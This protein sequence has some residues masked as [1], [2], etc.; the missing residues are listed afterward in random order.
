MIK[1][2]ASLAFIILTL[3]IWPARLPASDHDAS[4]RTIRL[5]P[6]R[7]VIDLLQP[8][9]E[10]RPKVG[11]VLSGGGARGF[12]HI[13]VLMGLEEAGIPIDYIVGS[14]MGSIIGGLYAAGFSPDSLQQV[15]ID[16]EW[17]RLFLDDP[18]RTNLFVAQKADQTDHT[19]QFRLNGIRPSIPG[20]LSAGQKLQHLLT[21]LTAPAN[22]LAAGDFS[23]L[24]IPFVAIATDLISG[25][26]VVLEHGNL[27]EAMR[28]S[29]AVPIVFRPVERQ[30]RLLVD[31]ALVEPMPVDLIRQR[32][33]DIVIAVNTQD[34]LRPKDQLT[35]P[36]DI[37]DQ[38]I[39]ISVIQAA[40]NQETR[41]DVMITPAIGNHPSSRFSNIDTLIA[42]GLQGVRPHIASIREL[43]SQYEEPLDAVE[44][45]VGRVTITGCSTQ[46]SQRLAKVLNVQPGRHL[47]VDM[48]RA[49]LSM[50]YALGPYADAEAEI[51]GEYLDRHV[52]YRVTHAPVLSDLVIEGATL[53]QQD[54]LRTHIK[55]KT[56]QPINLQQLH[57][58]GKKIL[59]RYHESGYVMADLEQ[60]TVNLRTGS[61]FMKI[62]EGHVVDIHV[63]GHRRTREWA[64][65]REMRLRTGDVY[66]A[67]RV[68]R[69]IMNIYS[70]G[71]FESVTLDVEQ[72]NRRPRLVIAVKERPS[73]I[74]KLGARY[75]RERNG[76]GVLSLTEANLF[77]TGS[78]LTGRAVF[79]DRRQRYMLGFR[80][81]RVFK[82]Y[83]T[84]RML[85][86]YHQDDRYV[87]DGL[88]QIGDFREKRSGLQ[89]TIGR[90][91]S[92]L[93]AVS[94][95][96]RVEGVEVQTRAG[97]SPSGRADIRSLTLRSQVDNLDRYPFPSSGHHHDVWL[98][99]AGEALGGHQRFLRGYT[100]LA[101]YRTIARYL[102]IRPK[103]VF[104]IGE[105]EI[106]FS[107]QFSLGGIQNFYGYR[108]DQFRGAY[109]LQSSLKVR[110]N[111]LSGVYASTRYDI[112]GLWQQRQ[113]FRWDD[114]RHGV[115]VG[116]GLATPVGP[117]EIH[118]GSASFE[119]RRVYANLGYRF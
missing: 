94:L 119:A 16:I 26:R 111:V 12:A 71:M 81:D 76:E 22:Y 18:A 105:G 83:M 72:K 103:F 9:T 78:R 99:V 68:N 43:L 88:Q 106:P 54:M 41:A 6:S 114:L 80:S 62:N 100:S 85:G 82:T 33:V 117:F 102:T 109:L 96:A 15:A 65:L 3:A 108:Q 56:G 59:N 21:T 93:G 37:V 118:Y 30:G 29:A 44:E 32:G 66:D 53:F 23:R 113:D 10:V 50:L 55:M 57:Q 13:G 86:Y 64:I 97:R 8:R 35:A 27:A 42:R 20:G 77:G 75:D 110:F 46:E 87:Y 14:S 4:T 84:Y 24:K 91:L 19:L 73:R 70:T 2:P 45:R 67:D 104:G 61:V 38:I 112:G 95:T 60:F 115:G 101:W 11:L 92:R 69:G 48:I 1:H 25:K 39:T 7:T 34:T 31:G 107:E 5:Q 116:V 89:F 51:F 79:G 63:T 58:D 98:E 17:V 36:W 74:V 47:M 49:D 90:Q 52:R 40:R 28:A